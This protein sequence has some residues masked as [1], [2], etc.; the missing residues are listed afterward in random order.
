[1]NS[2]VPAQQAKAKD[3]DTV[4]GIMAPPGAVN[5]YRT[6]RFTADGRWALPAA[7]ELMVYF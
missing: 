1:M 6:A 5:D 3:A 7:E 4:A 2:S